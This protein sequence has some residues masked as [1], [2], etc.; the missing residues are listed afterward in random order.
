MNI[1]NSDKTI[2]IV[3]DDR[4]SNDNL[5]YLLKFRFAEVISAYDGLEGW[6]IYCERC[7]DVILTDIDMPK[8]DGLELIR[9]IRADCSSIPIIVLS[10]YSHQRY[11]LDA[12][13]LKL[14]AYLLKPITMYKL[15]TLLQKL[16]QSSGGNPPKAI[17]ID[18]NTHYDFHSKSIF[19][20]GI[21][22]RLTHLEIS[23]IELLIRSRGVIVSYEE[24]EYALYGS[25]EVS[26]NALK[27]VVSNLRKKIPGLNIQVTP[28]LGYRFL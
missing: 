10:S 9:R 11:L 8:M 17:K 22:L 19:H 12:I 2:L 3:E 23:L 13:P 28:K 4:E 7:P 20:N 26:R 24:I 15:E 25:Q 27:I 14:E 18:E 21:A 16:E 1:R 6:R 5:A